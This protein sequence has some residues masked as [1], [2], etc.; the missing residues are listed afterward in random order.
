MI[1]HDAI[2]II[3]STGLPVLCS[4]CQHPIVMIS[5]ACSALQHFSSETI[6]LSYHQPT[7][8]TTKT[9]PFHHEDQHRRLCDLSCQHVCMFCVRIALAMVPLTQFQ[10]YPLFSVGGALPGGEGTSVMYSLSNVLPL[11]T[12]CTVIDMLAGL[13]DRRSM[14][15]THPS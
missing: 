1:V 3:T 7:K 6:G 10:P 15:H 4:S 5:V 8:N 14:A 11:I 9:N 12:C 13:N 2:N